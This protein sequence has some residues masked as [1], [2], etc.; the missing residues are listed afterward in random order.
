MFVIQLL[1]R[2]NFQIE[3]NGAIQFSGDLKISKQQEVL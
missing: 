3:R 1:F 2:K